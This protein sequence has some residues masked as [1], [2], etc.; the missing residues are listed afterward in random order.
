[1]LT[2]VIKVNFSIPPNSQLLNAASE[3]KEEESKPEYL[4]EPKYVN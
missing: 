2:D 1:M 4:Q 3:L